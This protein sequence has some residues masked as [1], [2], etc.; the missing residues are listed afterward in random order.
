MVSGDVSE[1]RS[2][3]PEGLNA[4]TRKTG[5]RGVRSSRGRERPSVGGWTVDKQYGHPLGPEKE[6]LPQD[7]VLSASRQKQ[8]GQSCVIPPTRGPGAGR[9]FGGGGVSGGRRQS[10][11]EDGRPA[12]QQC[13]C[14]WRQRAVLLK[15]LKWAVFSVFATIEKRERRKRRLRRQGSWDCEKLPG[16]WFQ[17]EDQLAHAAPAGSLRQP[18]ALCLSCEG[19]L[20]WPAVV[21]WPGLTLVAGADVFV[22]LL[23]RAQGLPVSQTDPCSPIGIRARP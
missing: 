6:A 2:G 19:R 1:V 12:V 5:A 14:A 7:T 8:K 21:P 18:S 22:L 11:A 17:P 16:V 13:E 23:A 15:G 4:G 9:A 10:S 3:H 20:V